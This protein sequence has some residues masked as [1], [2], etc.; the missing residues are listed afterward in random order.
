MA[1]TYLR[2]YKIQDGQMDVLLVYWRQLIEQRKRFGFR[3][4]FA[5]VD[6]THNDLVWAVE[7]DGDFEAAEAEY[8]A[9]PQRAGVIAN[10]PQVMTGV[11]IGRATRIL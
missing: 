5:C 2:R 6:E 9:S 11:T 7:H 4:V 3:V 1:T 10:A 8:F